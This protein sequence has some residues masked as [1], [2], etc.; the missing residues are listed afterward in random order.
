MQANAQRDDPGTAPRI[1]VFLATPGFPLLVAGLRAAFDE[2]AEIEVT[3][4]A[5][6][7]AGLAAQ[8]ERTPADVVVAE[9]SPFGADGLP[10]FGLIDEVRAARPSA[11]ILALDCR[12]GASERFSLALRA[13]ADGVV[14]R[15]AAP[16]DV[17]TAVR[18]ISRGQTYVSPE[19][20]SRMVQAYV[21]RTPGG[22]VE[23]AY[24][25]LSERERQI[26]LLA[27]VG[28]TNREIA[29]TVRLGEQTVH[30]VR[31]TVMEK[32]GFHDRVELLKY[33][34]RRGV[35]GVADL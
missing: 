2:A 11:R 21:L 13:G 33:A 31:A 19:I 7:R 26:L 6:D 4:S 28:H 25:A 32:L 22:T 17:V 1:R 30:H 8:L 27:A 18:A 23:D 16:S 35:V 15:A 12:D 5:T 24:D 9:A 20:V 34:L 3:G 29:R 14:T 10:G